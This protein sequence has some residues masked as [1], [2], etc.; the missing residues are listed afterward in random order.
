MRVLG[1]LATSVLSIALFGC[2][3]MPARPPLDGQVDS[4]S[5]QDV[6]E[7]IA[8]AKR[9]L[10]QSCRASEPV[11]SVHIES[12][13]LAYVYHGKRRIRYEETEKALVIHRVKHR[14][15]VTEPERD[16]ITG[17]NIPVG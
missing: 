3:E 1:R 14:W 5:K 6:R 10:A 12:A 9:A 17:A 8:A 15:R 13:D 16:I 11:Y 4:V 7:I 2:A